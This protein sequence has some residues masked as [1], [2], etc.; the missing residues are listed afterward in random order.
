MLIKVRVYIFKISAY[1]FFFFCQNFVKLFF[2]SFESFLE[3]LTRVYLIFYSLFEKLSAL[4]D[5]SQKYFFS[6]FDKIEEIFETFHGSTHK[7]VILKLFSLIFH[8]YY[9]ESTKNQNVLTISTIFFVCFDFLHQIWVC[10]GFLDKILVCLIVWFS[11]PKKVIHPA[12][13]FSTKLRYVSAFSFVPADIFLRN[14]FL[15]TLYKCVWTFSTKNGYALN[16]ATLS[17]AIKKSINYPP[18]GKTKDKN[19]NLASTQQVSN[20]FEMIVSLHNLPLVSHEAKYL[21]ILDP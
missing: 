2:H 6:R 10:F 7:K 14:L 3:F 15:S 13:I 12:Q 8:F 17:V 5:Y 11:L 16:V 19:I 18:T 20:K 4:C 21:T 1:K 9:L